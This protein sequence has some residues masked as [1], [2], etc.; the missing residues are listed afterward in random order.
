MDKNI[1]S[2][3]REDAYTIH[4]KF[5]PYTESSQAYT[6]VTHLPVKEGDFVIVAP[7][8]FKEF[9][10]VKVVGVDSDVQI[11]PNSD[12]YYKWIIDVIDF[13]QYNANIAKNKEVEDTLRVAYKA[14]LRQSFAQTVLN[15]LPDK[16]RAKVQ[17]QLSKKV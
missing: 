10:V 9:K 5:H 2:L 8:G 11:E 16:E 12:V 7:Q 13:D 4:V 1:V 15:S 3:L 14:N 6:Y 17:R